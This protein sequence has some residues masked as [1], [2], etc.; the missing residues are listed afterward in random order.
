MVE[1]R[2]TI[3]DLIA[4]S[5]PIP[6]GWT[7]HWNRIF[8]VDPADAD[9]ILPCD[10]IGVWL[11]CFGEDLLYCTN[12]CGAF[13]LDV[14]WHPECDPAGRYVVQVVRRS[15]DRRFPGGPVS[16]DW[17]NPTERWTCRS[18]SVLFEIL[19]RL[20]KQYEDAT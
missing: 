17:C 13:L 8:D 5:L 4:C 15:T 1:T 7:I 19:G 11:V 18:L 20:A 3:H 6:A 14:G 2:R 16:G 9:E 10:G 12:R